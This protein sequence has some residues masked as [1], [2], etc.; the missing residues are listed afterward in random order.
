MNEK[1]LALFIQ[2]IFS[3]IECQYKDI[4]HY[5]QM[6]EM[7]DGV[8]LRT[9]IIRPPVEYSS[10]VFTR[11]CYPH[12]EPFYLEI[13]RQYAKRGM[14]FVIQYCRGVGGSE[15]VWE[16]NIHERTDGKD[17]VD[18]LCDQQWVGNVGYWGS[19]YLAMTGWIIA[20]IVPPKVKTM[21][22]T[23]SGTDRH[24]SAYMDGMF[25]Q[26]VLTA[27]A[28][29]NA[30][31]TIDADY[32]ESC[33]YRP[34]VQVDEALWGQRLDWYR[35]WITN[36]KSD[37]EYWQTGFWKTLKDVPSKINI[38][39]SMSE[40]WYDHHLGS[41][42]K[43][44][45]YLSDTAR[46]QSEFII[47]PWNHSFQTPLEDDTGKNYDSNDLIRAFEWF[48][49][50]LIKGETPKA[51]VLRYI[52]KGDY[53]LETNTFDSSEQ[54][55]IRYYLSEKDVLVSNDTL[56]RPGTRGYIYDPKN[57]IYS[58][59]G[60]C[61]LK[62]MNKAGSLLQPPADYRSD[63]LSFISPPLEKDITC[64]GSIS[65][66]LCISSTA[67][68]TAFVVRVMQVDEQGK[69]YFVRSGITTLAHNPDDDSNI[70]K[71][72][73]KMW[74]IAWQF[75]KDTKI[76][77]D[78]QSSDFPQY[79]IH[80]NTPGIWSEQTDCCIAEQTIHFDNNNLS[81]I[82]LPVIL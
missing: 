59:G 45:K 43:T 10:T 20:D 79:C 46:V 33:L 34:H 61:L 25:R 16:P 50:I 19:S 44:Y 3:K 70:K 78:I 42:V 39:I 24:T 31:F 15:G 55:C 40:G 14:A 65:A 5:E 74:D 35:Q 12:A 30:G 62:T 54:A 32:I 18:W 49:R 58:H 73:I 53:W 2:N 52:I 66:H 82:A 68:D 51:R 23:L 77:I 41:A 13:A 9:I 67:Q 76:R 57:P 4:N 27:W 63:V 36:T 17:A 22:L 69:S 64:C 60:E 6:V 11:T 48:S 37:D 1:N 81:Y 72:T 56:I 21:Y 8:K 7:K 29:G 71:I 75:K 28:M 26:D 47:G 38:P 80:T